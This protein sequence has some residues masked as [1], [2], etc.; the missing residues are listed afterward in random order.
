MR[1]RL[2]RVADRH[3]SA[4]EGAGVAVEILDYSKTTGE[5]KP[6]V[7]ETASSAPLVVT[8]QELACLKEHLPLPDNLDAQAVTANLDI[9]EAFFIPTNGYYAHEVNFTVQSGQDALRVF[10][11][12]ANSKMAIL[13][14]RSRSLVAESK[15]QES[16]DA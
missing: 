15:S 13:E 3:D 11:A 2:L 9:S 5:G 6:R 16:G 12:K 14:E 8:H 1:T 10:L 7:D 4:S